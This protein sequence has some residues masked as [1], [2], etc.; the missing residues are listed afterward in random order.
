MTLPIIE[1][2]GDVFRDLGFDVKKSEDLGLRSNLIT[3]VR[4]RIAERI[5]KGDSQTD[6]AHLLGVTQPRVS[7]LVRGKIHLF[8]IDT[9]A[10]LLARLGAEV[11]VSVISPRRDQAINVANTQVHVS[12]EMV[13]TTMSAKTAC[14]VGTFWY[15]TARSPEAETGVTWST[16]SMV[17]DLK[18]F[19]QYV[20]ASTT[21]PVAVNT[22]LALAA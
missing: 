17:L 8:S 16:V 13:G 6:I 10:K 19:G 4:K 5:A 15:E 11:A 3:A 22:Q 21:K 12:Y 7:D 9:L 1:S 14:T 20:R 2:S 18:L